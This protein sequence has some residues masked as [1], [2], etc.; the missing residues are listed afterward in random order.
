[1]PA[2][3]P[4]SG[5]G[6]APQW[7]YPITSTPIGLPGPPHLPLGGPAGLKSHTVRNLTKQELPPPVDH[8]LLDVKHEPGIRVPAPAKH[9]EYSEQHPVYKPGEVAYPSW[10]LPP[11]ECPPQQ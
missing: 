8:F 1:M 3:N 7:G 10:D 4:I 11:Q 6:G 9:V 2:V 5:V